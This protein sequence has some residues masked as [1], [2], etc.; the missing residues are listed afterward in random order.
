[1][2]AMESGVQGKGGGGV[3][4]P[5]GTERV[6]GVHGLWSSLGGFAIRPLVRTQS[7]PTSLPLSL[8][9]MHFYCFKRLS[10]YLKY[11]SRVWSLDSHTYC[12]ILRLASEVSTKIDKIKI[13][14]L[15]STY[16]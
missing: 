4:S 7:R 12:T 5:R 14:K 11:L 9:L 2:A 8:S 16:F 1:M 10:K 3:L 6:A 13:S 15:I